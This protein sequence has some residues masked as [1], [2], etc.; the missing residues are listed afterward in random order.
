MKFPAG[1][2]KASII[3]PLLDVGGIHGSCS[4]PSMMQ[5]YPCNLLVHSSSP[6]VAIWPLVV[7]G[8]QRS[9]SMQSRVMGPMI[10]LVMQGTCCAREGSWAIAPKGS[11]MLRFTCVSS[12]WMSSTCEKYGFKRHPFVLVLC[13]PP[14]ASMS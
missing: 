12:S 4:S 13:S 1:T 6:L 5:T 10:M 11:L 3:R 2:L 7:P 14:V 9:V 8:L